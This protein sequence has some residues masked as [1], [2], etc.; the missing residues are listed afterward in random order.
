VCSAIS[1]ACKQAGSRLLH[2]RMQGGGSAECI[3]TAHSTS[4]LRMHTQSNAGQTCKAGDTPGC[5]S[6]LSLP[7][8]PL[9]A[10]EPSATL[11]PL[12]AD[13]LRVDSFVCVA[14]RPSSVRVWGTECENFCESHLPVLQ[15]TVQ[16]WQH[17]RQ[18]SEVTKTTSK[19]SGTHIT[20]HTTLCLAELAG[21]ILPL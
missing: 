16:Q 7:V 14:A 19:L 20:L 4:M 13:K 11:H 6:S 18:P 1:N 8:K 10:S 9:W 15:M 2:V 21:H 3:S 12:R 17:V 5:C